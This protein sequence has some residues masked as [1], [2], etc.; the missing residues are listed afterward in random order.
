M[1]YERGGTERL[2]AKGEKKSKGDGRALR[3]R[4]GKR[5]KAKGEMGKL[6]AGMREG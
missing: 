2:K 3:A 5:R 1:K 6:D 4:R